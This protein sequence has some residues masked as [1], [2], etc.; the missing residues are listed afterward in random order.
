MLEALGSYL[1]WGRHD[2]TEGFPHLSESA[3]QN[4]EAVPDHLILH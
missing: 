4:V 1:G 3:E 2:T